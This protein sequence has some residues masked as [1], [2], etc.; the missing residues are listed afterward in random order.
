MKSFSIIRLGAGLPMLGIAIVLASMVGG[1]A[2]QTDQARISVDAPTEQ[3]KKG[4][5]DFQVNILAANVTNLAAFQFSLAYDPSVIKYV[6]VEGG[7]F[8][9]ST[10]RETQCLDPKVDTGNPEVLRYNCVTLGPPVS[11]QGAKAGPNGSGVLATITFSPIGNGST[12][13]D[14]QEGR[15]IA[16][17]LDDKGMP[18]EMTTTIENGTIA[19][20]SNGSGSSLMIPA[21]AGG[22]V[23]VVVVIGLVVFVVMR[24]RARKPA[25]I[26]MK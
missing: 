7:S 15:M 21:I 25:S 20:G 3:I 24:A 12:G 18:V 1:A 16:A 8:L 9:G 14:L 11:V 4:D 17:E 23:A 26:G 13:L 2:A 5:P 22:A 6:G 10:G 19:V